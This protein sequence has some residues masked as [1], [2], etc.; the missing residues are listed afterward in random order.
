M[1]RITRGLR[2][3]RGLP[4]RARTGTR[5]EI[6]DRWAGPSRNAHWTATVCCAPPQSSAGRWGFASADHGE[7][8][9]TWQPVE[10]GVRHVDATF[11]PRNC[12]A[13]LRARPLFQRADWACSLPVS[14]S[15]GTSPGGREETPGT[16]KWRCVFTPPFGDLTD[17]WDMCTIGSNRAGEKL[18]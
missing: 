4:R 10:K 8:E 9:G 13:W 3:D 15:T 1:P 16:K 14:A 18:A 7:E 5:G 12:E 11:I 6:R 17:T 2:V